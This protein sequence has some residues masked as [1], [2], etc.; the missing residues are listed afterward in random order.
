MDLPMI[1][2]ENI[3]FLLLS[4]RYLRSLASCC[5]LDYRYYVLARGVLLTGESRHYNVLK[6]EISIDMVFVVEMVY[7]NLRRFFAGK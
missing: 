3:P 7:D 1:V 2:T 6:K 5:Y 4:N